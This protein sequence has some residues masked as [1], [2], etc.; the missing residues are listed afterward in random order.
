MAGGLRRLFVA[1]SEP[2]TERVRKLIGAALTLGVLFGTDP[3]G[4]LVVDKLRP[5]TDPPREVYAVSGTGTWDVDVSFAS[6]RSE[7]ER[8]AYEA[9][10]AANRTALIVGIDRAPGGRALAGSVTDATHL[11][12]ALLEYGFPPKNIVMLLDARA[13]RDAILDGIQAL[14][15]RT[16][17]DGIA[18]FGLAT[19]TRRRGGVNEL[20]TGDG[21]RI[22]AHELAD[23]MSK[24]RS[25]VWG[26]FPTCYA[27]GYALPG[28]VGKNRIATFASSS[29]KPTYQLGSA[30]SYLMINMVREGMLARHAPESVESAFRYA[31]TQLK[32]TFPTRV[33]IMSDGIRGDMVLGRMPTPSYDDDRSVRRTG[34]VAA[35]QTSSGEMDRSQRQPEPTPPARR[36]VN[37]TVCAPVSL[38]C[39]RD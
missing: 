10:R 30:G 14:A 2:R 35:E 31:E 12:N 38:D 27:A 7:R 15:R 13:T 24:I 6:Q 22:T 33:P 25:R 19:H 32:R 17:R 3:V 18:V 29:S 23:H 5:Q 4:N 8:S 28:I 1:V 37:V 34:T 11:K 39:P 21:L 26:T 9:P 20:L 16:P 36:P